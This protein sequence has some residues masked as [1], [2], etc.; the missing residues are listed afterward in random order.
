MS[1]KIFK[2][3]ERSGENVN[4]TLLWE[5]RGEEEFCIIFSGKLGKIFEIERDIQR[6]RWI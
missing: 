3:T 5:R 2:F 1:R 4:K 6:S